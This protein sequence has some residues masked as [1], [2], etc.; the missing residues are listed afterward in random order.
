[1]TDNQRSIFDPPSPWWRNPRILL[2]AAAVLVAAGAVWGAT[3]VLRTC[4][5]L[6][7]DVHKVDGECVGVTDGSYVFQP[8]F[9]EVQR[10]IAEENADVREEASSYVTVALLD[11]LIPTSSKRVLPGGSAT[12]SR[13][14]TPRCAESTTRPSSAI[15]GHRSSWFSPA[16]AAPPTSGNASSTNWCR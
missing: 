5:P 2:V 13:A 15:R 1:M 14:R 4:W 10:K 16:R 12:G 9:E 7:S 11:P 8:D 3:E 6:G